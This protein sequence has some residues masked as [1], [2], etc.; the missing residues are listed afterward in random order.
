MHIEVGNKFVVKE[1][2]GSF[3]DVGEIAE[4]IELTDDNMVSFTF[5]DGEKEGDTVLKRTGSMD[6]VTF[7]R[8]F[9]E[10]EEETVEEENDEAISGV[11]V[12][13]ERIYE[14]LDD[15][16]FDV[17]TVFDKCT[18]V[19]CLLPNGTVITE[20]CCFAN[21]EEY[22]EEQGFDVCYNEIF[23]KVWE[24]ESYKYRPITGTIYVPN[25]NEDIEADIEVDCENCEDYD[26]PENP[27]HYCS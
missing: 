8:Y 2:L 19:S 3:C 15:S 25:N 20:S 9:E 1:K 27:H 23:G 26:C 22:D 4:V 11:A 21:S 5:V 13:E 17:Y 14:I 16:K 12:C 7:E 24:F 18:V 10:F 6:T